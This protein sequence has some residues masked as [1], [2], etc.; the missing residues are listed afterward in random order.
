VGGPVWLS[1]I[2]AAVMLTVAIYCAGRL[3]AARRWRR[4][5]EL[6]TDGAH[7][8]MGVAMA[9]ML[10]SGLRTLPAGMWEGVFAAGAAWFGGQTLRARRKTT[11]SNPWRC[12]HASP[13]LV[14]CA[15]MLYMFLLLP[16][17]RSTAARMGAMTGSPDGSRFS[18]LALLMALFL[19]G[20]VVWLGD[21]LAVRAPALAP[22]LGSALA[23][24]GQHPAPSVS[25]TAGP[26]PASM[27][28]SIPATI[29]GATGCAGV[30]PGRRP[31]ALRCAVLCK[32]AMGV[33]MGYM[34]ILML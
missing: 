20:H 29:P 24:A 33:T 14:E 15:A 8:V 21:R 30:A 23:L 2:F 12:L 17:V 26:V 3:V 19:L 22:P 10:V 4:P 1:G 16:T 13:H 6:D 5:T 11:A 31:L 28:A 27:P 18:F 7:V 32:I 25:E 34:L 9:G